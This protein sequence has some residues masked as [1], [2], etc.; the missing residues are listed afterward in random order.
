MQASDEIE[1]EYQVLHIPRHLET[2]INFIINESKVINKLCLESRKAAG[3]VPDLTVEPA[4]TLRARL[5]SL[6][7]WLETDVDITP[8]LKTR[9]KLD[10]LLKLIYATP[11]Y[12]F[13]EPIPERARQLYER[14]EGQNWGQG[15]VLD[16]SS[17]AEGEDD[18]DATNA[19]R[20]KSS[21]GSSSR[22]DS[23]SDLV[24]KTVKPPPANHPIWGEHG[25]MHGAALTRS[26]TGRKA[27]IMDTRYSSEKRDAKVF[28]HN[29]L[30]VGAWFA[31]QLMALFHGAHGA[32]I[33]GIAGNAQAG[34]YSVVTS[35]G[36]YEE[37]DKDLGDILY[38]S[39]SASHD[40]DNP[41]EPYPSSNATLALKASQRMGKPV[42]VLRAA[43]VSRTAWKTWRP[44]VGIRYDGLYRVVSM[45]LQTNQKRGLYEQFKLERLGDQPPLESLSRPTAKEISDFQ[46]KDREY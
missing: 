37:L 19:K 27:T 18:E 28:G 32:K 14:W 33:G 10:Q 39:G 16:D 40:N 43:G 45:S 34:A 2:R 8:T 5:E 12:R 21:T 25:I 3:R 4:K 17:G 9:T 15:E 35:G 26:V 20:R 22:R 24:P 11:Q 23:I 13:D 46:E 1:P 36:P 31:M 30:E 7:R 6:M 38:Y 44:I 42:R 29:G 41:K